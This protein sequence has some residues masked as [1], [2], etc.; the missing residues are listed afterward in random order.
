MEKELVTIITPCH[1]SVEYLDRYWKSI[2][3]QTFGMEWMQII[4]V[5]DASDDDGYTVAKLRAFE[6]QFPEQVAVIELSENVRQ[7][8]ARNVAL[9]YARGKYIQFVDSDD[10]LVP[11]AI[12]TLYALAEEYQTDLIH[13]NSTYLG[14]DAM[15]VIRNRADRVQLLSSGY[16]SCGHS[17]KF[18]RRDLILR[19]GS[20]FAVGKVYEEPLFTYPFLFTANRILFLKENYYKATVREASTMSS[21]AKL[22]IMDHP[23]VQLELLEFLLD[24]GYLE[25]YSEEIEEYF[26]WSFFYEIMTNILAM[27]TD[28]VSPEDLLWLKRTCLELFP[29]WESNQYI[30]NYDDKRMAILNLLKG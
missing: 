20:R 30:K 13:Y 4:I 8:G 27:G 15:A 14:Q 3:S 5:D 17:M 16:F 24:R 2:T 22:H 26:I 21:T 10:E 11:E 18:Y 19:T 7:G 1:N 6:T 29:N 25:E 23:R 12:A 9:E 28:C